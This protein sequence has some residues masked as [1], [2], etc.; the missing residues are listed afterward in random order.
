M[1]KPRRS[2]DKVEKSNSA[3][4]PTDHAS[5]DGDDPWR[6]LQALCQQAIP[7]CTDQ[8]DRGGFTPHLTVGQFDKAHKVDE[9]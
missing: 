4:T 3:N 8:T 9:M 2:T 5:S 1:S 6:A 7:H